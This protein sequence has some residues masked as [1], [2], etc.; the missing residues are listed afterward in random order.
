MKN[1][2][3][4]KKAQKLVANGWV[5]GSAREE[6]EDGT[7]CY[8][9]TG[10]IRNA[11]GARWLHRGFAQT[12]MYLMPQPEK[13][14]WTTPGLIPRYNDAPSTTQEDVL[15]MFSWAIGIELAGGL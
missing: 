1:V 14:P 5:Q 7:V 11:Y 10:A 12:L 4:L 3:I 15:N 13:F 8:C 6:K 2:D 9:M